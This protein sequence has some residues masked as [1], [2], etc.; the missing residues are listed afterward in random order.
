MIVPLLVFGALAMLMY[1]SGIGSSDEYLLGGKAFTPSELERAQSALSQSGL[2]DFRVDGNRIGVAPS[3][4]DR[5]TATLV[6][7][8]SLPADFAQDFD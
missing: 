3:N 6:A 4:V 5:Y 8:S 2:T 7:N 1:T